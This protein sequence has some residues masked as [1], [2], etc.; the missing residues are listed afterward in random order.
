MKPLLIFLIIF[1]AWTS[2]AQQPFDPEQNLRSLANLSPYSVGAQGFDNRY[3][4]IRGNPLLFDNWQEGNIHFVKQDTMSMLVKFNVDLVKQVVI[5]QLRDGSIG[6]IGATT[7]KAFQRKEERKP[8]RRWVVFSE[9]EVE[10]INSVRLKFYEVLHEGKYQ[11]LKSTE[12]QLKK[13]SYEGAYNNGERYDEFL[14]EV[15]YWLRGDGVVYKKVKIKR[16]DIES[17][18]PESAIPLAKTQK[19]DLNNENDVIQLLSALDKTG[20]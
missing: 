18:L 20:N 17:A 13:A 8:S 9:K 7:I 15:Y 4:G 1:N 12:K 19:L 16:K 3:E 2:I 10:K 11:L 6:Q 14:T 5:V